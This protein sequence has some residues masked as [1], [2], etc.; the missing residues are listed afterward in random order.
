MVW[1]ENHFRENECRISNYNRVLFLNEKIANEYLINPEIS[2]EISDFVFYKREGRVAS[3]TITEKKAKFKETIKEIEVNYA[4]LQQFVSKSKGRQD[5][6]TDTEELTPF[7]VAE[8]FNIALHYKDIFSPKLLFFTSVQDSS[9]I[10]KCFSKKLV[11]LIG[12]FPFGISP[13]AASAIG[14][15]LLCYKKNG[16]ANSSLKWKEILLFASALVFEKEFI[17]DFFNAQ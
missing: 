2:K 7:E 13:I 5:R 17:N 6:I 1:D 10:I 9:D 15:S 4:N 8:S 14:A 3:L 12:S 11:P 16:E